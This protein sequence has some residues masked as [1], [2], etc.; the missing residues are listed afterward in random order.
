M[1]FCIDG[2]I[3]ERTSEEFSRTLAM[4]HKGHLRPLCMCQIPGVPMYVAR[5]SEDRYALK[6]MP[7]SAQ[8]HH[9]ECESYEIPSVLSGRGLVQR[10][11][12]A[13]DEE[14]GTTKIRLDI[15]L[16]KRSAGSPPVAESTEKGVVVSEPAKL[17]LRSLL[18]YLYEEAGLSKWSPRMA[19]KRNWYIVRK[20]LLDSAQ[21]VLLG[22]HK[23]TE[24]LLIPETF[25]L[26]R[27]DEIAA[28]VRQYTGK[29]AK[30]GSL[31]PMGIL[32]GEVKTIEEARYGHRLII[33]HLPEVPLYF[34]HCVHKKLSRH[35][36][37][38]LAYHAEDER[39]HLITICTFQLSASGSPLVEAMALMV[40]DENWLPFETREDAE[41]MHRALRSRRH[42][43]K[44]LR[45][46][47]QSTD[48]MA[49]LV[50]TDVGVQP[51]AMFI[52]PEEDKEAFAQQVDNVAKESGIDYRIWI[53]SDE[54]N[55][56][57]PEKA[58]AE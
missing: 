5:I 47:L 23:L 24:R 16:N 12:I 57:L 29:F 46:N 7:N 20:Y 8:Q 28:R 27:K 38:E 48:I 51:V 1:V 54:N 56:E 13:E 2:L 6:R 39:V 58:T 36:P 55:I 4:A 45:Y 31:Q 25:S 10:G 50:F 40:T 32:I 49:T 14:T 18:H 21:N 17:T 35:F 34:D 52:S 22:H 30:N 11:A 15:I 41:I 33:R 53:P 43:I 19:G 37:V 44:G 3:I 42:F 26:D 9:P